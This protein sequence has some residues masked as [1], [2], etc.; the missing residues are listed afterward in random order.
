MSCPGCGVDDDRPVKERESLGM[1]VGDW[2]D[3]CWDRSDMPKEP[4]IHPS[5]N[6]REDTE[7]SQ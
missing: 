5:D 6:L 2:H 1:K 4:A 3:E 7:E